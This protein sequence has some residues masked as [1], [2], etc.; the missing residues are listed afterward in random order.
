MQKRIVKWL[1]VGILSCMLVGCGN[2]QETNNTEQP[3]T[4]ESTTIQIEEST[5]PSHE[6]AYTEV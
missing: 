6:H 4:T 1:M 3:T 2:Q 5:E